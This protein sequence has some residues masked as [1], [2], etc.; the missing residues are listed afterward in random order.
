MTAFTQLKWMATAIVLSLIPTWV[1]AGTIK[2]MVGCY[3]MEKNGQAQLRLFVKDGAVHWTVKRSSGWEQ[4]DST[5]RV[6]DESSPHPELS[7]ETFEKMEGMFDMGDMFFLIKFKKDRVQDV[8]GH[9]HFAQG[10]ESMK[11]SGTLFLISANGV[12]PA[13]SVACEENQ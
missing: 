12:G 8:R 11:Q 2:D 9:G 3:T 5:V 4:Q 13:F 6:F 1:A 10:V 7:A